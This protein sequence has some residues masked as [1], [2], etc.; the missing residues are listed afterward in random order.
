LNESRKRGCDEAFSE[1]EEE[2]LQCGGGGAAKPML[3]FELRPVGAR[4]NWKHKLDKQSR[5]VTQHRNATPIDNLGEEL[6]QALRRTIE[7]QIDEDRTLTPYS[8]VHGTLQS[9]AFTPAFQ[10]TTFTVR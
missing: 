8:T 6:T 7:R 4:L 2:D 10:S 5:T 1:E 9:R 3:D